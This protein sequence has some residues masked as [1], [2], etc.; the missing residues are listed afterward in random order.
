[1]TT[2][3]LIFGAV[4]VLFAFGLLLRQNH[5]LDVELKTA[6]E[7]LQTV[8]EKAKSYLQVIDREM[9]KKSPKMGKHYLMGCEHTLEHILGD[10]PADQYPVWVIGQKG[11]K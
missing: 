1:M 9:Q 7:N 6:I 3:L 4:C 5:R 8:I 10:R 2:Y 11:G